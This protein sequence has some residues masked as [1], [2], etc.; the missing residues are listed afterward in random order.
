MRIN[1][2]SDKKSVK[3]E[4]PEE[5]QINPIFSNVISLFDPPSYIQ[6]DRQIEKV[7]QLLYKI[8][9]SNENLINKHD[10]IYK[11]VQFSDKM[12][13]KFNLKLTYDNLKDKKDEIFICNIT[14]YG[15]DNKFTSWTDNPFSEHLNDLSKDKRS[16]LIKCFNM[17]NVINISS[18][19]D[20][21]KQQFFKKIIPDLSPNLQLIKNT[22]KKSEPVSIII[23]RDN[24]NLDDRI[25]RR[26]IEKIETEYRKEDMDEKEMEKL[27]E[28]NDISDLKKLEKMLAKI[29]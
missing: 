2:K 21:I 9:S 23:S 28:F 20:N 3:K 16:F 15:K 10:N 12:T 6:S 1:K 18:I 13:L 4:T 11:Y 24:P 29:L 26:L 8:K 22:I 17:D 27:Y 25:L 19:S 5:P 14:N 7:L